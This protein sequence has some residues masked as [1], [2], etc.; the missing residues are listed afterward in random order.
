MI[1]FH[2][3]GITDTHRL[4]KSVA[5][6]LKVGDSICLSGDLGAGKTE[7]TRALA[8][9]LGV[10]TQYISSPS[11][12]IVN[13][14]K[15]AEC[16]VQHFDLYRLKSYE[17]LDDIGYLEML[18]ADAINIIEWGK[19]FSEYLPYEYL[20]IT[21]SIGDNNSRYIQISGIGIRG[22]QLEK[23]LDSK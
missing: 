15:A 4:A 21:I 8:E 23:E 2:S 17:Q 6:I 1:E 11:F 5:S 14:Y 13:E 9:S 19:L 3:L 12:T 20:D 7:F 18:E 22:E 16:S 10:S